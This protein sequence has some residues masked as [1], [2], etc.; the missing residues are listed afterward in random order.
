M[1]VLLTYFWKRLPIGASIWLAPICLISPN[2]A[3]H[4]KSPKNVFS[5][6]TFP[7]LTVSLCAIDVWKMKQ[8]AFRLWILVPLDPHPC[9]LA[10]AT[11]AGTTSLPTRCIP[12]AQGPTWTPEYFNAPQVK[13]AFPSHWSPWPHPGWT[14]E[15]QKNREETQRAAHREHG[16]CVEGEDP[17]HRQLGWV[18]LQVMQE[19]VQLERDTKTW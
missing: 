14:P 7:R 8:C 12:P 15:R 16:G 11:G 6:L 5:A 3:T 9:R 1:K 10:G 2:R 18:V 19:H 13:A 17:A 4:L